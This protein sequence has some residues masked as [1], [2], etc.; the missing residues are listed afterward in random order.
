MTLPHSSSQSMI[1]LERDIAAGIE[2][3]IAAETPPPGRPEAGGRGPMWGPSTQRV[4]S[5]TRTE[6]PLQLLSAVA[7]HAQ[8]LHEQMLALTGAITG[9][10][11]PPLRL[12]Q[13][14][15]PGGGLLPN[16]ALLAHEIETVHVEI[17]GLIG[18]LKGRL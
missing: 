7:D 17:A 10:A 12:R 14:P 8:K 11:P 9:E 15:R 18:H 5:S 6:G 4:T 1:E 13:A 3:G 2:R 16:V